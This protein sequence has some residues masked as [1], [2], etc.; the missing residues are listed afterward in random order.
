TEQEHVKKQIEVKVGQQFHFYDIE[1]DSS[2]ESTDESHSS[3]SISSKR[4]ICGVC[5]KFKPVKEFCGLRCCHLFC[6]EC[7]NTYLQE[8]INNG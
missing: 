2:S 8:A 3:D 1:Q 4:T 7:T 6:N 5:Y